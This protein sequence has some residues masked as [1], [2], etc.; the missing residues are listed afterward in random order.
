MTATERLFPPAF[1]KGVVM[2]FIDNYIS[3][4]NTTVISQREHLSALFMN[5]IKLH[6]QH[7][8]LGAR[9]QVQLPLER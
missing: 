7:T 6:E 3:Y 4:H 2:A 1:Y 8:V 9:P 5:T